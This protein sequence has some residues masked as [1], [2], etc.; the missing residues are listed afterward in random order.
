LTFK[1]L[2]ASWWILA[3]SWGE[4]QAPGRGERR[5]DEGVEIEGITR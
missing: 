5:E 3:P 1:D 2:L 4:I